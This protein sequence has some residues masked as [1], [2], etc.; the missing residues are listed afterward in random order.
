LL[1]VLAKSGRRKIKP[2]LLIM[3]PQ[4]RIYTKL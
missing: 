4:V 1:Y 3:L 2:A